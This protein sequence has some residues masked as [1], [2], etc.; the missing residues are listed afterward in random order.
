MYVTLGGGICKI[1][2]SSSILYTFTD[3]SFVSTKNF[4][5][6]IWNIPSFEFSSSQF[7]GNIHVNA[8]FATSK[9]IKQ[10]FNSFNIESALYILKIKNQTIDIPY[11][12]GLEC[13]W[14]TNITTKCTWL[15]FLGEPGPGDLERQKNVIE[16]CG[17]LSVQTYTKDMEKL[18]ITHLRV[19]K[20]I[21]GKLPKLFYLEVSNID[22]VQVN[23]LCVDYLDDPK[24]F[25]DQGVKK[26]CVKLI[27]DTDLEKW[28]HQYPQLSIIKYYEYFN[29][30]ETFLVIFL[31]RSNKNDLRVSL[32]DWIKRLGTLF[33]QTSKIDCLNFRNTVIKFVEPSTT[34]L[35]S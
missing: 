10:F 12:H 25:I 26:I 2:H 8:T 24:H 1:K 31:K 22:Q 6:D 3:G 29:K 21:E 16:S 28:K 35:I 13:E 17:R 23:T 15:S 20:K 7:S 18:N 4:T 32:H 34:T 33:N 27:D 5:F 11:V 9:E 30:W 19:T 14:S